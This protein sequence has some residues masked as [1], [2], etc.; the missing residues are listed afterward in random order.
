MKVASALTAKVDSCAAAPGDG[1]FGARFSG[2]HREKG[3]RAKGGHGRTAPGVSV[4]VIVSYQERYD[5]KTGFD[6][7]EQIGGVSD[8]R[9]A[10]IGL[11]DGSIY[12]PKTRTMAVVDKGLI[13]SAGFQSAR[14][15]ADDTLT[16]RLLDVIEQALELSRRP[17]TQSSPGRIRTSPE[18]RK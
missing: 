12:D 16:D 17:V 15:V 4:S 8:E 13:I 7:W 11:G 18:I 10:V 5:R 1:R 2:V 6:L 14:P 9:G 3:R